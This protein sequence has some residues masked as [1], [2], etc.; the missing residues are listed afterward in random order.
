MTESQA[1][2]PG[3]DG[4][5]TAI[6]PENAFRPDLKSLQQALAALEQKAAE[7][8]DLYVRALAELDNVRKRADRDTEAARR[9][10]LE[11]FAQELLPV[12]DGFEGA[13]AAPPGADGATLRAGQEATFR[14]LQKAVERA[15]IQE[16][17]P[18][19]GAFDPER[20]EAMVAKPDAAKPPNTVLETI[21]KGYT[22][23]G[24]LLR[25]ARVIVTRAPDA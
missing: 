24:R 4:E 13:L 2:G 12:L 16:L 6:L 15:G 17:A 10:A 5:S 1:P 9:Y 8:Y 3:E 14:L 20:H 11:R 19:G 21:Q 23:N 18:T 7:H 22:L 25:P